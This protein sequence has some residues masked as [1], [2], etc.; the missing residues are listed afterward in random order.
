MAIC[1]VIDL[2]MPFQLSPEKARRVFHT[3]SRG[4]TGASALFM[5]RHGVAFAKW[6]AFANSTGPQRGPAGS[7]ILLFLAGLVYVIAADRWPE[8]FSRLQA[9]TSTPVVSLSGNSRVFSGS[10]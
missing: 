6:L 3:F 2:G 9:H 1:D 5:A 8:C 10:I 7:G 4:Q